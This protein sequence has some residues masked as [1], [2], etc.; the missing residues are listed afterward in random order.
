MTLRELS[1]PLSAH[2]P[3]MPRYLDYLQSKEKAASEAPQR[4]RGGK[5]SKHGGSSGSSGSRE[6]E[7]E[8]SGAPLFDDAAE[9]PKEAHPLLNFMSDKDSSKYG[10]N[11][12]VSI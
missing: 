3:A 8:G 2:N 7:G 1:Q 12:Q 6:V 11:N 4:S 9:G 10:A 5:D